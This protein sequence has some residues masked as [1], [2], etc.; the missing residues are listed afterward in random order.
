MARIVAALFQPGR[1]AFLGADRRRSARCSDQPHAAACPGRYRGQRAARHIRA[2][3]SDGRRH[4]RSTIIPM[5]S[6]WPKG[7]SQ[8]SPRLVKATRCK[9]SISARAGEPASWNWL[10]HL[11]RP[12]GSRSRLAMLH[13]GRATWPLCLRPSTRR[14]EDW[15]G[16]PR[17]AFGKCAATAGGSLPGNIR[18][19]MHCRRVCSQPRPPPFRCQRSPLVGDTNGAPHS[20]AAGLCWQVHRQIRASH[21]QRDRP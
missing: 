3:L 20:A 14:S 16:K 6:T 7:M 11:R 19:E 2:G 10:P 5:S 15:D 17:A 4:G 12:A 1:S 9:S 13:R 8:L 21:G 18:A